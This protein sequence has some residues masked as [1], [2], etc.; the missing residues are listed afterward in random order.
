[1]PNVVNVVLYVNLELIYSVNS[2]TIF[3]GFV[4]DSSL[5]D[6]SRIGPDEVEQ[7]AATK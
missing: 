4:S 7:Y 1:M 5:S 3:P 6:V 2:I